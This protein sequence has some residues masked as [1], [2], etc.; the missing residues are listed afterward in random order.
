MIFGN[1]FLDLFQ[2]RSA[3]VAA[4]SERNL[5]SSYR[6]IRSN[7]VLIS[8]VLSR[9]HNIFQSVLNAASPRN[10]E[11]FYFIC[12]CDRI[13]DNDIKVIGFNCVLLVSGEF[14][15]LKYAAFLRTA[16]NITEAFHLTVNSSYISSVRF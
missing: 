2:G 10:I 1:R 15:C 8:A 11:S 14:G 13:F 3:S 16:G 6:I 9:N 12:F 4:R 7:N 5:G